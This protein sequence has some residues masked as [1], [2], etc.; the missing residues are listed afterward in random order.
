MLIQVSIKAG[1]L[2]SVCLSKLVYIPGAEL[3]GFRTDA[4]LSC[5]FFRNEQP[6]ERRCVLILRAICHTGLLCAAKDE[7]F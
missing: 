3:G 1:S 7:L 5:M 4:E 2:V 6:P